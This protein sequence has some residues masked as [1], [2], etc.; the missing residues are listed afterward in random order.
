MKKT[1]KA[2]MCGVSFQHELG[3]TDVRLFPTAKALKERLNCSDE[4]GIAEVEVRFKRWV[5]KPLV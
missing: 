2:F 4:C 5:K 3:E 1:K